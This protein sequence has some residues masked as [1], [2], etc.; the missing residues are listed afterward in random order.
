MYVILSEAARS[1]AKSKN[2]INKYKKDP[3][4]R[5]RLAQDDKGWK[6]KLPIPYGIGS[7]LLTNT[8]GG[9]GIFQFF[10]IL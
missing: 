6:A 7:S 9:E 4:T 2:L 10:Q 1:A 8:L 3:S 5:R